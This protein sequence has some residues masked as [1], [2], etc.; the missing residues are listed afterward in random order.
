MLIGYARVSTKDQNLDLQIQALEQAGCEK[1]YDDKI[2]GSRTEREGLAKALEQLRAGDTFVVWKLDRLGRT[3]KGL[4]DF[5]NELSTR[6]VNFR[7]LTDNIDT[8]SAQG[9][10]FFHVMSALAEMEKALIVERTQ[11]GLAVAKAQGRT[12]GR[13]RL[14]TDDKIKMAKKLLE[15]GTLPKDVAETLG[16]SIPTLYRHLP[17]NT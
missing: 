11:A 2:S 17:A 8:S 14:F 5:V 7:S 3:T 13:K 12:G 1:I 15:A 9:R 16:V 6:E 10:F 4:I